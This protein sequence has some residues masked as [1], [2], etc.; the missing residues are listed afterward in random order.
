MNLPSMS[1]VKEFSA[2]LNLAIP[3]TLT[4]EDTNNELVVS[5]SAGGAYL[6]GGMR[7]FMCRC[8]F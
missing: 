5:L 1:D 7:V 6:F 4:Y 2:Y 3:P 8:F